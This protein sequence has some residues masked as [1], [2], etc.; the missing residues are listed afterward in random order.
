MPR[1]PV[2]ELRLDMTLRKQLFLLREKRFST[3][4]MGGTLLRVT[5]SDRTGSIPGV[6]FDALASQANSLTVGRGVKVTGRVSE[7]KGQMQINIE[8]TMNTA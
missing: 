1:V 8:H 2:V 4:R 5:L 7:Y 3:A 6:W